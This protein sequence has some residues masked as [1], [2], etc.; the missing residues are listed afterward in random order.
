MEIIEILKILQKYD[1]NESYPLWTEH[2]IIG[3]NVDCKKISKE[4][5]ETLTEFGVYYDPE[6]DQLVFYV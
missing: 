1:I 4:D 2:N 5:R 6:Y 3:F